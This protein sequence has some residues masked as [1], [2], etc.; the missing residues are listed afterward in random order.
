M[1][2]DDRPVA[3]VTGGTS[4]IGEGVAR[5]LAGAGWSVVATGVTD[6]EIDAFQPEPSIAAR[7][8]DVTDE[9]EVNAFVGELPRIDALVNC[10]GII[11]RGGREFEMRHFERTIE[12]NLF[13][14]MRMCLAARRKL[15]ASR[16]SIVNLASMLT[17]QGS[18]FAPGYAA[19]KGAIGQLTKSLAAAW[20]DE[21]VRVNAVAPGWIASS[22]MDTYGGAMKSLIH[23]LRQHVPL[24]RMGE[25]A[26]VS[27]VVVFLLSPGAAFVTGITVQIDGASSL[28]SEVFPL[29]KTSKSVPFAGFHRAVTPDVLK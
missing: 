22:G 29:G 18:A 3:V 10:A 20:A 17:F 19:S 5:T 7:R 24:R 16:G 13:G 26:E 21:G 1:D 23:T 14:T 4:G 11:Q 8:L 2:Q 27:A 12:V 9:A 28:G 15:A 6:G 25:E